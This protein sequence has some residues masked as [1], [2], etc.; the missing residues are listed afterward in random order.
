[1]N[2]IR[3]I[4]LFIKSHWTDLV[5]IAIYFALSNYYLPMDNTDIFVTNFIILLQVNIRLRLRIL[6]CQDLKG[7][8][9]ENWHKVNTGIKKTVFTTDSIK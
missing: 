4:D 7:G 9:Q 3:R 6:I 1:M 5:P 2:K 8:L